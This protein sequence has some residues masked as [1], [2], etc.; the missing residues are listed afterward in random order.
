MVA[1]LDFATMLQAH[2]QSRRLTQKQL[3]ATSGVPFYT[4]RNWLRG[5]TLPQRWQDVA[6][7]ALAL[8]LDP[9]ALGR[10]LSAANHPSLNQ[11]LDLYPREPLLERWRSWQWEPAPKAE[12]QATPVAALVEACRTNYLNYVQSE[13]GI[14]RAVGISQLDTQVPIRLGDVYFHLSAAP[15]RIGTRSTLEAER[16]LEVLER[17][18]D[19]SREEHSRLRD[20]ILARYR[21]QR[22]APPVKLDDAS[23]GYRQMVVLGDP[24]AGKTTTLR[25]IASMHAA[26][27]SRGEYEVAALGAARLP[28][29]VRIGEFAT[30]FTKNPNIALS[31]F[32]AEAVREF[33]N[34]QLATL[35][36]DALLKGEAIVLLDGFDE[37]A[38]PEQRGQIR[39]RIEEFVRRHSASGNHFI[40]SSRIA[41][42]DVTPLQAN[43]QHFQIERMSR[44]DIETFITIWSSQVERQKRGEKAGK[45]EAKRQIERIM[46]AVDNNK[47][48]MRL[49]T[50]PL[51]LTIIYLINEKHTRLPDRRIELYKLA[52][53]TLAHDWQAAK[54][55]FPY[56]ALI[57]EAELADVLGPLAYCMHANRADGMVHESEVRE[58]LRRGLAR[59]R[60]LDLSNPDDQNTLNEVA[61]DFLRRVQEF[62][63]LFV[64]RGV[65][66]QSRRLY[67]FMHLTFEEYY[68][69]RY[70]ATKHVQRDELLKLLRRH[71]YDPRWEEALLLTLGYV[72]FIHEHHE[73]AGALLEQL[74][75]DPH[76]QVSEYEELFH[77]DLL[78]ALRA[79]GDGITPRH[80][81][82]E[83]MVSEVLGIYFDRDENEG[84]GRYELLRDQI[85][86]RFAMV[87]NSAFGETTFFALLKR[88]SN[89]E[90]AY[91]RSSATS[92]LGELVTTPEAVD[93]LVSRLTSD[94]VAVVRLSAANALRNLGIAS[95]KAVDALLRQLQSEDDVSVRRDVVMALRDLAGTNPEVVDGLIQTLGND[96]AA[97][98]RRQAADA[99]GT[100]KASGGRVVNALV[101]RLND[102]DA[103]VRASAASNLGYVAKGNEAVIA[104]LQERLYNDPDTDMV[105]SAAAALGRLNKGEL[106]AAA[107][108]ERLYIVESR[109]TLIAI[110]Q[111]LEDLEIHDQAINDALSDQL[112]KSEDGDVGWHMARALAKLAPDNELI[113]ERLRQ[114]LHQGVDVVTLIGAMTG[115]R[116]LK[117]NS[118]EVINDLL[119]LLIQHQDAMV[120]LNA[121]TTL[122]LL[123]VR[124]EAVLKVMYQHLNSDEDDDVRWVIADAL[125]DVET[126]DEAVRDALWQA[127]QQDV[128]A[129][130]R[131][132][133]AMSLGKAGSR[134]KQVKEVLA[135][136]SRTEYLDATIPEPYEEAYKVLYSLLSGQRTSGDEVICAQLALTE[137]VG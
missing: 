50:N 129:D 15:V 107:L 115:L 135:A 100:M 89:D 46:W 21:S 39:Q 19:L 29:F 10:L 113:S 134:Q 85:E 71:R 68:A 64:E 23:A 51:M 123:K 109:D 106:A 42:Y 38:V 82:L 111:Q 2:A 26:A 75:L 55:G 69:A 95:E 34:T 33:R 90:D 63:G 108:L 105:V 118:P 124:D 5:A 67:S 62:T 84:A 40:V 121:V 136:L 94:A 57:K 76:R 53:D 13:H 61:E 43:W 133:A 25:Y 28:I 56:E 35:F 112:L 41:G 86:T 11:L 27:L 22:S 70:L 24:G 77:R 6:Q 37:V 3:A 81:V 60:G 45:I 119:E 16:D 96:P 128:N 132:A 17:R 99:L 44:S 30:A 1:E 103:S 52:A 36:N 125:G 74:C 102:E 101:Q 48:V 88:M 80:E 126:P 14:L 18:D 87:A 73:Q 110:A 72:A 32:L 137:G 104:T 92:A 31:D 78:F 117:V 4:L 120:R 12:P 47:G 79:S 7:I 93:A 122:N 116:E 54:P 127:L 130:V 131:A 97:S 58:F 9:P 114:Q 8:E 98:I 59:R 66:E 83:A 49:A 65:D 91:V 20:S